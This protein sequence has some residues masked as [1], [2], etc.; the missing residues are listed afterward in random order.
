MAGDTTE[1]SANVPTEHYKEFQAIFQDSSDA[2]AL[3]G[4]TTWFIRNALAG[5]L[6]EIRKNPTLVQNVRTSVRR[7][8]EANRD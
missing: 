2:R 5:F 3:Y 7:M 1:F 6:D 4:A 8:V